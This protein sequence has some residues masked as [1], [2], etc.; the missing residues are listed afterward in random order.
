[1]DATGR[2]ILLAEAFANQE[3]RLRENPGVF[4]RLARHRFTLG[5]F[6]GAADYVQALRSR[7]RLIAAM[8][9]V[10]DEVDVL[11][12]LGERS[13]APRFEEAG[14]SFPFT[15]EPSLRMPFSVSGHPALVVCAGFDD[16]GM[17]LAVQIVGRHGADDLVLAVG[18]ALE[19][20]LALRE[21]RPTLPA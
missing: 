11:M 8:S 5:A 18:H 10:F 13:G 16:E 6:L 7:E 15:S 3:A 14:D 19:Q 2:V 9:A 17:P 21:R 20:A 12:T 1:M 4:G